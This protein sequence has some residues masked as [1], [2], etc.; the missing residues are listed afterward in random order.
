MAVV[1]D[2]R[3]S[4]VIVKNGPYRGTTRNWSNRYHFEGDLPPDSAHWTTLVD[5]ITA[6]EKTILTAVTHIIQAVGY[7]SAS[8]T[9][10]NPHGDAVFSKDYALAGT[11]GPWA[12]ADPSPGD[13]ASL[14]RYATPARSSKNHPVYL[15]NYYHGCWSVAGDSDTLNAALKVALEAYADDWL[16]GFGDGAETHV[17]CGPHGAVATARRV[18]PFVRHRD[19]PN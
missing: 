14:V 8:A 3:H 16:A 1:P 13:A 10:T 19:F 2:T 18:D 9:V 5:A 7:D 6:Q 11:G 15:F 4:V 17:R 12:S